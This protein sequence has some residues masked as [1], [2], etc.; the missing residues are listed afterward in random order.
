MRCVLSRFVASLMACALVALAAPQCG[1]T[2]VNV[3]VGGTVDFNVIGGSMAGVPS[4]SP[5]SMS[6][7]VDSNVFIDSPNFPTRGYPLDLSSFVM[8]VDGRPVEIID[9]QPA[10]EAFF[11]LRDNDP[12]VDGVFLSTNIDFPFPVAVTIPGLAPEHELDFL[13]TFNDG[14]VFPSLDILD[15]LGTYGLENLSSFDWSIG[16]FGADGAFYN[17]ETMTISAVPEPAGLAW[18][19]LVALPL[20][21]RWRKR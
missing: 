21:A 14:D 10:G 15:A 17:Y 19:A 13:R 16:R 18:L 6:F 4:G 11:V 7:N 12:A 8:L 20:A 9:P 1:A 3:T 5:V 2:T